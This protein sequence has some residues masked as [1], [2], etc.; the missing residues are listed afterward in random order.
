VT[1]AADL[2]GLAIAGWLLAGVPVAGTHRCRRLSAALGRQPQRRLGCYRTSLGRLTVAATL[3]GL[4]LGLGRA[5]PPPPGLAGLPRPLLVGLGAAAILAL[6]ASRSVPAPTRPLLPVTPVERRLFRTVLVGTA[7]REEL[8]YRAFLPGVL[9]L[10]LPELGTVGAVLVATA[11]FAAAHGYQGR[12][13]MTRAG[14]SG[15]AL[16]GLYAGTASLLV[17][18]A[19]HVLIDLRL[20]RFTA[21]RR[22]RRPAPAGGPRGTPPRSPRSPHSPRYPADPAPAAVAA[23]SPAARRA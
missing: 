11:A 17:A 13:G 18:V 23:E 15:L 16:A 22:A 4:A 7:V 1:T 3:V 9:L 21:P 2:L 10:V 6:A 19:G 12:A 8:T 20:M 5:A 14:A